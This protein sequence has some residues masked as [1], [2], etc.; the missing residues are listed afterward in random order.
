MAQ[1]TGYQ[2]Y[3]RVAAQ[4][5]EVLYNVTAVISTFPTSG[6]L[7]SNGFG[8]LNFTFN[9]SAIPDIFT[10]SVFFY[11]DSALTINLT[12]QTVMPAPNTTSA[13]QIPVVGRYFKV[14]VNW[15]TGPGTGN[16]GLQVFGAN[17]PARR[18]QS[19]NE[20]APFMTGPL[21]LA[22]GASQTLTNVITYEGEACV[23]VGSSGGNKWQFQLQYLSDVTFAYVTLML[24]AGSDVGNSWVQRIFLPNCPVQCVVTNTDTSAHT[25]WF[26]LVC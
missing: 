7:D 11:A 13:Y 8:F 1:V 22:G 6:A 2:D 9:A 4:A 18:I 14:A 26:G 20:G 23:N 12:N 25:I 24:V 19:P 5:G 15:N 16:F 17:N 10:V 3:A 21:A